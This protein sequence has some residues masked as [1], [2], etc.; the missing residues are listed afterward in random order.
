MSSD[1]RPA[2]PVLVVD[3]DKD[4]RE[5]Y[6]TWLEMAGLQVED[7]EDAP[8]ALA[9][10]RGVR[11][12]VLV[13]E[14]V[15]PGTDGLS[16]ARRLRADD[17]TRDISIILVTGYPTSAFEDEIRTLGIRAVL[18]KPCSLEQLRH[19]IRSAIEEAS[20]APAAT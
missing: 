6:R 16:L 10:V 15:L 13:T 5:L 4:T 17:R 20:G 8:C 18:L 11:P 12:A 19:E 7:A 3:H 2:V 9:K 1:P 14:I